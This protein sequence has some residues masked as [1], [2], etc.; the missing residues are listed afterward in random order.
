MKNRAELCK[1]LNNEFMKTSS[2]YNE[3]RKVA[4]ELSEDSGISINESMDIVSLKVDVETVS[5]HVLYQI[6]RYYT[7]STEIKASDY[8]TETEIKSFGRGKL[9]KDIGVIPFVFPSIQVTESQWIG[10]ISA[11]DLMRLRDAQLIYYNENTQRTLQRVVDGMVEYFKITLNKTALASIRNLLKMNLFIPNTLTLNIP[12]NEDRPIYDD[13]EKTLTIKS[14]DHFDIIDGY[15]RYIALSNEYNLNKDFDYR[16]ELRITY[17]NESKAQQFIHQEDQKTE[18]KKIDSNAYN[19]NAIGNRIIQRLNE[20][21]ACNLQGRIGLNDALVNKGI[22]LYTINIA[23]PYKI[24]KKEEVLYITQTVK[25]MREN[26]NTITEENIQLLS[27]RWTWQQVVAITV[28]AMND[29]TDEITIKKLESK[30]AERSPN[31]RG[32]SRKSL[33]IFLKEVR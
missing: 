16:M 12:A 23:R 9:K 1:K 11:Q 28:A 17:F 31:V 14:L 26:I 32:I 33:S 19:Q 10:S 2:S 5:D 21:G 18:M 8:F 6:L 13:E 27:A 25:K 20:D 4:L 7:S 29:I 3:T 30:I 24:N 15:H 22:M